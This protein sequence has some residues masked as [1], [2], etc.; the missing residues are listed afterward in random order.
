MS[1]YMCLCV[2]TYAYMYVDVCA[3]VYIYILIYQAILSTLLANHSNGIF[4]L[5]QSNLFN[6][7]CYYL[8]S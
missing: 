3:C 1:V 8:H 6:K 2:S 7:H 5:K 4:Y